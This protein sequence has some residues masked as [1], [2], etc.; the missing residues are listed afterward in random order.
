MALTISAAT[1]ALEI[2]LVGYCEENSQKLAKY[3]DPDTFDWSP[4]FAYVVQNLEGKDEK[5]I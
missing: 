4:Y 2:V 5:M 1:E 3:C